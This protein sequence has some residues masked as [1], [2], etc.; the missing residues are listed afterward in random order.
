[1]PQPSKNSSNRPSHHP[2][3]NRSAVS[4]PFATDDALL[5]AAIGL[6]R[7]RKRIV[8]LGLGGDQADGEQRR[9][10][11]EEAAASRRWHASFR[12]SGPSVVLAQRC[13]RLRL[14]KVEREIVAALVL[15]HLAMLGEEIAATRE[16]FQLLVRPD[17]EILQGYRVLAENGRLLTS[18]LV[19]FDRA[20][21]D[22][23]DRNREPTRRQKGYPPTNH[24]NAR[25]FK[26]LNE[27]L[28][29][30]NRL[31]PNRFRQYPKGTHYVPCC[32]L[33][34]E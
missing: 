20:D 15:S 26:P 11:Q 2:A 13:K 30:T 3:P 19:A 24:E 6:F 25:V 7:C 23:G 27:A 34:C 10:R 16:L 12:N 4:R 18:G 29:A 33:P 1:M 5:R 31:Y 9:L 28:E 14:N 22:I 21:D 17:G 8:T 32:V